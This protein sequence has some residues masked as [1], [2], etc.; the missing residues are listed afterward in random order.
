MKK[1]CFVLII[2]FL[3]LIAVQA[4]AQIKWDSSK[5]MPLSE[6]AP[7][8]NGEGYTVFSGTT[9]EKFNF[10]VVSIE[11]NFY[12][13]WHVIW[14]KGSGENFEK[15]GVAG[16]MSGSP[17]YINGRLI[18][19]IS[20]GYF[21]QREHANLMG[22]T[23]IELMVEVTQR[24][25]QPNLSYRG[26]TRFN[27]GSDVVSDGFEMLPLTPE[28]KQIPEG[29]MGISPS[30][31]QFEKS[32]RLQ[33]PVAFAGLP[34]GAIGYFK[35]FFDAYHLNPI[36]G[37][38][39]GSP[40]K[41]AP[42]EPGQIVGIEFVRG[43]FPIFGYGTMT[44]VEGDQLLGFGHSMFGEGNVN[45]PMSGGHVHFILPSTQRSSKVASPTQ[46]IGT[47]VQD[48]QA[49]IAGT[50]GSHPSYI[51]VNAKIQTMDGKVHSTP[52]E[53][54][55]HR[56]FST[57]YTLIPLWYIIDGIE[58]YSG[59]HSVNVEAKILLKDKPNL[60]SREIVR[61]NVYSS[62]GSPGFQATRALTPLF[63]LIGNQYEKIDV[64]RIDLDVKMEDKR[65]TAVIE[66]VRI[67]KDRYRPGEKIEV[68]MRL[69]PYL[70]EP[71][72]KTGTITIPEDAPEGLTTLLAISPN[73]YEGWQQARAPLNY[74]PTN[75]N[76]LIRLLQREEKNSDIIL[77]LFVPKVG[78]TV[79][80]EEFPELP[81]SML[82]VMNTP[83]QSG[84]GGPTRGTTL[85]FEK[86]TTPYVVSGSRF[87]RFTID[88]NAP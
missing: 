31:N 9:V 32:P 45:L 70:E 18:G 7:G 10:K 25:M 80:G 53:V 21:Y 39:G 60:T 8:M 47:L 71:I 76:Q 6:I 17:M 65:K 69:R 81:V 57:A 41:K 30:P 15:T 4:H 63:S 12:P 54:I 28:K 68:T 88:R 35:Q 34:S 43:A 23:P 5:F 26:G 13:N 51:P 58:I 49:A 62:S 56:D 55:R 86:V 83:T 72:I 79:H 2:S 44:Y 38:G 82:S 22:V 66:A 33:M 42:I 50:I 73:L 11:Y 59:D 64:E 74:Q 77:E 37:V 40:V 61:R 24:G 48:R 84:E 36:Q 3:C 16:G 1:S 29:R 67:N 75:I 85:H 87:L 52:Y 78:M 27:F 19:A 20:L 14:V 46:P